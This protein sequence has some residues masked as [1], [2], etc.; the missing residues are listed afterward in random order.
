M[1]LDLV[2]GGAWAERLELYLILTNCDLFVRILVPVSGACDG[3]DD[4]RG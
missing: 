2:Q 1:V 4:L 3:D